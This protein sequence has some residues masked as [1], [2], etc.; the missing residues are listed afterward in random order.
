[1]GVTNGAPNHPNVQNMPMFMA[2]GGAYPYGMGP[3]PQFYMSPYG[4]MYANQMQQWY[5][6]YYG[7]R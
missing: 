6:A 4:Q 5:N 3:P 1:M 2:G 7:P